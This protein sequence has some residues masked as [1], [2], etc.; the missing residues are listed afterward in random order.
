MEAIEGIKDFINLKCLLKS[1][2][3]ICWNLILKTKNQNTI[4]FLIPSIASIPVNLFS[5]LLLPSL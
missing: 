5:F 4:F 2:T 1:I 3:G